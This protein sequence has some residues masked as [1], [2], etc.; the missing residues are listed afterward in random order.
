MQIYAHR[1]A[2][3][4][5]PE[6]TLVAFQRAMEIGADGIEFDVR[7][8]ADGIPVVLHDRDV[9]RT[10]NGQGSV[11]TLLLEKIQR[12]DMPGGEKIP[13]L[14]ETLALTAGRINLYI[15]LTQEGIE[16]QVLAMLEPYPPDS[17]LIGSFH[18]EILRPVRALAPDAELWLIAEEVSDHVFAFADEIRATAISLEWDL[19]SPAVIDRCRDNNLKLAV[20]TVNDPGDAKRARDMG[21]VALC[22]DD[23]RTIIAALRDE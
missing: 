9:S 15:E 10:T 20:W 2:S 19:V 18:P 17:W 21:V 7:A 23:P 1:G 6:N 11:D 13:T 22:T 3:R 14:A 12:L 8:S 4:E 5:A 16:R